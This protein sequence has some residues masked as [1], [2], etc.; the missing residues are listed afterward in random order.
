M[1]QRSLISTI[2]LAC[3]TVTVMGICGVVAVTPSA[4]ADG[5][6]NDPPFNSPAPPDTTYEAVG[7]IENGE[8][9]NHSLEQNIPVDVIIEIVVRAITL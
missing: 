8:S 4:F 7:P 6:T 3:L 5:G 9:A 1:R 2:L